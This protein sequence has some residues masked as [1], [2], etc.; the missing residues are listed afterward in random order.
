MNGNS[1]TV[2]GL[3]AGVIIGAVGAVL[4][5]NPKARE[6]VKNGSSKAVGHV[7]GHVKNLKERVRGKRNGD[8]PM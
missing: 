7:K 8:N 5:T 2:L 1:K 4:A 6:T 3:I